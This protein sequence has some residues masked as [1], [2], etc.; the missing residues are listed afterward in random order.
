MSL[1]RWRLIPD[2]IK[3]MEEAGQPQDYLDGPEFEEYVMEQQKQ[4]ERLLTKFHLI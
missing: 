3:E 4:A 1:K 2:Y